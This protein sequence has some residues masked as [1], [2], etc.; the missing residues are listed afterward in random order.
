MMNNTRERS[1]AIQTAARALL[2]ARAVDITKQ[3]DIAALVPA[4]VEQ[5]QCHA[6]T[7]K[8]HIA[9][10]VR[11]ARGEAAATWGGARPGSGT[12]KIEQE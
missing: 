10:A 6:D 7:A 4:L 1:D 12:R 11:R 3:V 8:R 2:E 9:K 5:T